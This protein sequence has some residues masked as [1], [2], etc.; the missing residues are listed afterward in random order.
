MMN[1]N[2][3]VRLK[4]KHFVLTLI[5]ALALLVQA[6][7]AIFGVPVDLGMYANRMISFVNVLFTVFAI[8]GIVNDPTTEGLTDSKNALN[9]H[10]PKQD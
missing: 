3:K 6:F 2:W 1:I 10:E 7:M 8:V 9:Y 4:N 5:P